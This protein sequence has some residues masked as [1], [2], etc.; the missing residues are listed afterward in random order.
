MQHNKVVQ[1]RN[2]HRR[3]ITKD[4]V[5]Q[6]PVSRAMQDVEYDTT[7]SKSPGRNQLCPCG[8]GQKYKH[9]CRREE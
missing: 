3:N 9:C 2:Q 7:F 4:Q 1:M 5:I 8:S 6:A